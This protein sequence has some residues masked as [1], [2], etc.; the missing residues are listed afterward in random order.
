MRMLRASDFV[1]AFPSLFLLRMQPGCNNNKTFYYTV[2][3][4]R[5]CL[6]IFIY[7]ILDWLE[8]VNK[9]S[10]EYAYP[11]VIELPIRRYYC[12]LLWPIGTS[13]F[14]VEIYGRHLVLLYLCPA[15]SFT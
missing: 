15:E 11:Y 3:A 4:K 8:H 14:K 5:A 7:L 13:S 1:P 6:N 2:C 12:S 10:L 9:I